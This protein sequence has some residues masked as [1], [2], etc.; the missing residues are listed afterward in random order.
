MY[1]GFSV[2]AANIWISFDIGIVNFGEVRLWILD[3]RYEILDLR[4]E[5]ID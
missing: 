1:D 3:I 5:T 2:Q 4:P